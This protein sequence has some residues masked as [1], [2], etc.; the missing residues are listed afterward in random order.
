MWKTVWDITSA[1]S[2]AKRFK[3]RESRCHTTPQVP[4]LGCRAGMLGLDMTDLYG[5]TLTDDVA[6]VFLSTLTNGK[7]TVDKD[8]PHGDL[9]DDF[10]Y[11]GPP[12]E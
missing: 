11:L 8:D 2:G 6:D 5:R 10:P 1:K 4:N 9:L 3:K 12:H 7:V